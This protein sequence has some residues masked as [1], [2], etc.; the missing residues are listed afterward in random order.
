MARAMSTWKVIHGLPE[1]SGLTGQYGRDRDSVKAVQA[2]APASRSW[3]IP[4]AVRGR[5]E[6]EI[7]EPAPLPRPIP[8]RKI[9]RMMEKV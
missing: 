7:R 4:S 2:I 1:S 6:R 8:A 9:A 5:V 3:Q